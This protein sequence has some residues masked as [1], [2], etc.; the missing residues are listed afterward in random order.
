[1]ALFDA[2]AKA[3]EI[4]KKTETDRKLK[5]QRRGA[6]KMKKILEQKLPNLGKEKT[7]EPAKPQEDVEPGSFTFKGK[8]V[9]NYRKADKE[10]IRERTRKYKSTKARAKRA[11][12]HDSES[13]TPSTSDSEEM[14]TPP[15]RQQRKRKTKKAK[16]KLKL[17]FV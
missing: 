5:V 7:K 1:M 13:S 8:R 12:E 10:N 2:A 4:L 9:A 6:Q 15:M 11:L 16:V 3:K 17:N 14:R